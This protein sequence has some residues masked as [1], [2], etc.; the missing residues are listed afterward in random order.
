MQIPIT[1]EKIKYKKQTNQGSLINK[2]PNTQTRGV[3]QRLVRRE[4][5]RE[6]KERKQQRKTVLNGSERK[7]NLV[8]MR[9]RPQSA[10]PGF[11]TSSSPTINELNKTRNRQSKTV[12]ATKI[13]VP[14]ATRRDK[15]MHFVVVVKI[16]N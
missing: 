16:S 5:V 10:P 3:Q 4:K 6:K 7:Q 15:V 1:P 14:Q 12:S 2:P 11:E 9:P 8:E 13:D